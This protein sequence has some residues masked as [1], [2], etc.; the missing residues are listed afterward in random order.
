MTKKLLKW[1]AGIILLLVLFC[2]YSWFQ[3]KKGLER[4]CRE[5]PAG[6]SLADA[7]EKARKQGFRFS[8]YSSANHQ[9]FVTAGG[10]MGRY[11]CVLEHD[12]KQVVK[13]SLNFND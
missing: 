4:Y 6:T 8:N 9:A 2:S 5:T 10:V 7:E 11:V 1:F 13:S 3:T 12:G